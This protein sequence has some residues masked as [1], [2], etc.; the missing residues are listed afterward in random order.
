MEIQAK[1]QQEAAAGGSDRKG[2]ACKH[3]GWVGCELADFGGD[4]LSSTLTATMSAE[5]VSGDM[6]SVVWQRSSNRAIVS[7]GPQLLASI[8]QCTKCTFN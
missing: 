2:R 8:K 5:A 3:G 4:E 1:S 7:F 6:A